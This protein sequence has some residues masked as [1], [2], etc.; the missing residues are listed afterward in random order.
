[1]AISKK[2]ND[3]NVNLALS[4][5]KDGVFNQLNVN[6]LDSKQVYVFGVYRYLIGLLNDMTKSNVK[7]VDDLII[8]INYDETGV[9]PGFHIIAE[10]FAN[11]NRGSFNLMNIDSGAYSSNPSIENVDKVKNIKEYLGN[12]FNLTYLETLKKAQDFLNKNMLDFKG[13]LLDEDAIFTDVLKSTM[14]RPADSGYIF[15]RFGSQSKS[16]YRSIEEN[17]D[18]L[19]LSFDL[20]EDI[21]IN[22]ISTHSSKVLKI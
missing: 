15:M 4:L 20:N 11:G 8:K 1:M 22:S 12:K 10:V 19:L 5:I 9:N 16:L 6:G 7:S 3:E 2:Y 14:M 18:S 21:R 17:F 13:V